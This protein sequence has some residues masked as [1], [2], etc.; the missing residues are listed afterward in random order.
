M[1]EK[2]VYKYVDRQDLL[3]N[4]VKELLNKLYSVAYPHTYQTFED[5]CKQHEE[6]SKN[7]LKYPIDFYYVP[8]EVQK[9]IIDDFLEKHNVAHHWKE[10]I[11]FLIDVLFKNGGIKEV[12]G[13][14][15]WSK[16]PMRHCVDVP[17]LDK[18]IPQEYADK[19][20]EV[21]DGYINT[22]K[23]G[24]AEYNKVYFS[25]FNYAPQ[26]NRNTVINSWKSLGV[27][28]EIPKDE[29]WVDEYQF[30]DDDDEE[31]GI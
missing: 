15:E 13:P 8:Q 3:T 9:I 7:G 4:L 17:T 16:E 30:D 14:T 28:I 2:I 10:D 11:E 22:Y 21:L 18:I 1:K 6:K 26:T 20:K 29:N 5:L 23:F 25:V 19:V 27:N 31:E 24:D 12:Y